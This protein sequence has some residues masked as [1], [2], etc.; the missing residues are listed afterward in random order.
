M[1]ESS[2]FSMKIEDDFAYGNNVKGATTQVRLGFIRKVYAILTAQLAVTTIV[3]ALFMTIKPLKEFTQNNQFMLMICLFVSLGLIVALHVKRTEFPM[4]MYLLAAFT[5]VESY[6]VGTVVTFYKVEIVIQ[7][8]ILTVAVFASL[9]SYAMQSKKDYSSW[10]AGLFAALWVLIGAGFL[11]AFVQNDTFELMCASVG[12]LVF[13]LFIIY[14]THLLMHRLS[15]E[16]YLLASIS[17][18]LD[19]I[20]LFL[21]TLRILAKLNQRK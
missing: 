7:A 12:A 15:P 4:N 17:L 20:N 10:G 8:F 3:S 11:G 6:T 18:Y 9:T 5:L 16:E 14:D 13:C 21:E 2:D 19:V 1:A